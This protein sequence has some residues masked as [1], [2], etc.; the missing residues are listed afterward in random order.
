[1]GCVE[2]SQVSQIRVLNQI[3]DEP[4]YSRMKLMH[5]MIQTSNIRVMPDFSEDKSKLKG[6]RIKGGDPSNPETELKRLFT[7]S[8]EI[9]EEQVKLKD[10]AVTY[11]I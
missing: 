6:K 2:S 1:M 4:E 8:K 5:E 7:I 9:E 3:V 11:E 10:K